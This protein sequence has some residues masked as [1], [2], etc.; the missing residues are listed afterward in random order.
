MSTGAM[1]TGAMGTAAMGTPFQRPLRRADFGDDFTWGVA[2]AAY[3]IEGG[4]DA[5]G[6]GPS[7]WDT[8]T[9]RPA[10]LRPRIADR[11]T[12][13]VACDFYHR[14][15]EDLALVPEMGF[16]AK[17]F[18]ISWP[19]VLPSGTGA[20][21]QAGLD[22]YSRV[23]DRCLELDVEPWVTLY[24]WDLPQVLQDRGGWANRDVLGWFEDYVG[25]VADAIGDRVRHWMIFN[26]PTS[27]LLVG[28]L[29][30]VHAPGIRNPM[31]FLA[32]VHHV[33]LAQAVGAR[34]LRDRLTDPVVGTS[35]YFAPVLAT[36]STAAHRVAQRS[37]G[38][39]INR[40]FVEPNLGLG[41][42]EQDC[43]LMRGV[44]RYQ[45]DGDDQAI[46]VDW[47]F[48]GVQYYTRLKAPVLPIP[49]MWSAPLFG[50]DH[51]NFDHR[52][53]LGGPTRW[54][55]RRAGPRPLL[56]PVPAPAHHRERR[57]LSR[58]AG[59]QPGTRPPTDRLL[60]RTS[61]PGPPR[62]R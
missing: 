50:R 32:S 40:I 3:Q 29:V 37:S 57:R 15:P 18:S 16:G 43:Q 10:R 28:D 13:D 35:Q 36:G 34:V 7:I 38:A 4:W 42:P 46:Q 52:H 23:V 2:T 5:D 56:W 1:S 24:H 61:A 12:G 9:H 49:L 45:R 44:R 55:L 51:R 33:N 30:G 11:S 19:R 8:F 31:T 25:V 62:R 41:Y 47:D 54:P 58:R 59:R 27:F 17:R 48:L 26:E 39:L 60:R 14:Y 6:K 53:R 21:N 20:V 22:F